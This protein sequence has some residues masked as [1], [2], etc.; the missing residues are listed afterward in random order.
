[1]RATESTEKETKHFVGLRAAIQCV[2]ALS[3]LT[4]S[5]SSVVLAFFS[6]LN[7]FLN[8]PSRHTAAHPSG[9]ADLHDAKQCTDRCRPDRKW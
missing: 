2:F 4:F 9:L 1:M 5:V 6:V 7:S 3:A 8:F